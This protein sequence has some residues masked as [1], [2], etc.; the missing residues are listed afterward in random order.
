MSRIPAELL[1]TLAAYL[2]VMAAAAAAGALPL[3]LA[4]LA[5]QLT[6]AGGIIGLAALVG[7]VAGN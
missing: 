4:L 5:G 1:P 6:L 7:R 3:A 2:L